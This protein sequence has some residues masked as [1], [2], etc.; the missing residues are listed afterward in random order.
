VEFCNTGDVDLDV[1]FDED[2]TGDGCPA[3]GVLVTVPAG[4]C[5]ACTVTKTADTEP[6]E[7]YVENTINAH[8]TL[9]AWTGLDN[10]WDPT[11]SDSCDIY[12]VKAGDK[13]EDI[14]NYGFWDPGE[15][16]A[17]GWTIVLLE[18]DGT[19]VETA[20]TDANG[21]YEFN[22]LL[23]GHDYV[24]CEVLQI[25]Y[26]QTW[27]TSGA[28]CDALDPAYG[29]WGY[30]INLASGEMHPD[31]DFGNAP[32]GGCT[33]TQG[34]WKT[35]S[36]YGPAAHP[37]DGWYLVDFDG[38]GIFEGPDEMIFDTGRSAIDL[39]NEPAKGGNAWFILFYQWAAAKLNLASGAGSTP[40]LSG[41][42]ADGAALLDMYDQTVEPKHGY[43]PWIPEPDRAIAVEIAGY[44][45][46]YNEG[47]I[48]PGHCDDET[49]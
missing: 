26:T 21:H 32:P 30:A 47:T 4:G 33:Y 42:L 14:S 20:T 10:Y 12:G 27:P 37:D 44:L 1:V 49:F 35:H 3:A 43:T 39:W 31:N 23:P 9:Q 11:A 19:V 7:S 24:V 15:L 38:D 22:M 6:G 36:I 25:G 17:S 45:A 34:Y 29:P 18:T 40:G 5:L 41:W 28:D 13:W 2:L 8:V 16:G 46:D 48:G